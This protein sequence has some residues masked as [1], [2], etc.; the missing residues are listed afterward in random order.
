V[1]VEYHTVVLVFLG[2]PSVQVAAVEEVN[3]N[4]REPQ[5][6]SSVKAGA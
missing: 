1:Y 6:E 2:L 3:V 5:L 4:P